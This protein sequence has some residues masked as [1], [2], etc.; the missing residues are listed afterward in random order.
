MLSKFRPLR[1]TGDHR[2]TITRANPGTNR[3]GAD[4][5]AAAAPGCGSDAPVTA[6]GATR[7][8]HRHHPVAGNRPH[9][10]A[11]VTPWAG[12]NLRLPGVPGRRPPAP[13]PLPPA[14]A[15]AGIDR[16]RTA[17]AGPRQ[18]SRGAGNGC[19]SRAGGRRHAQAGGHAVSRAFAGAFVLL[20]GLQALTF[21]AAMRLPRRREDVVV[22][23]CNRRE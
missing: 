10:A 9:A 8:T 3:R 16:G 6:G 19:A 20:C 22:M 11:P 13:A 15:T 2:N 5:P 7:P 21:V 1:T 12:S 14:R 4:P 18:A 17:G 23:F